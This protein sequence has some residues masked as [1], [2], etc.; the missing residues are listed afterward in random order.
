VAGET[1]YQVWRRVDGSPEEFRLIRTV[2]ADVTTITEDGLEP[3]KTY[4]Y[5]VRAFNAAG[6]SPFSNTGVVNVAQD[7]LP[8]APRELRATVVSPTKVELRW[9]DSTGET[10]Y[11][12]ERRVDGTDAWAK[13]G[14]APANATTFTDSTVTAGK[15]YLYRVR[16]FNDVGNSP[17]SNTAAAKVGTEA[18]RPAAPRLEAGLIGPRAARLTWTNVANETGYRVERRVDGSTE[19]WRLVRTVGADVTTITE[20]GLDAGKTYL[21]RVLAFNAAGN[22]PYS[23]VAS[24]KTTG[25]V[26]RPAAPRELRAVAVSPTQVNLSWIGVDGETGYRVERRLD[27]TDAWE[28]V[29]FT[30]ADVTSYSDKTVQP[31]KTYIYR[32]RT[33]GPTEASAWSNTAAAK[34]PE[35]PIV[36][37]AASVFSTKR[38]AP[39]LAL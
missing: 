38:I 6:N 31:G 3:G 35:G 26:T 4:L 7:G 22:S 36:G 12:V 19:E 23:N 8:T 11:R 37:T 2:G 16:A 10:G 21:Y 17:Y 25:E 32:V 34:T 13:I 28:K 15:T 9:G 5:R 20:D 27:G 33:Q 18:E 29:T 24:V 39:P 14:T 1:G 30:A